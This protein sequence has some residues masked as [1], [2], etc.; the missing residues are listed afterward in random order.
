MS[1]SSPMQQA[2]YEGQEASKKGNA[3]VV[4]SRYSSMEIFVHAFLRGYD[5]VA[6][7]RKVA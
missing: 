4:P 3:R 2:L 1:S 6:P 5:S 7:M